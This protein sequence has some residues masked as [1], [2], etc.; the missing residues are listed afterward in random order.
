[1]QNRRLGSTGIVVSELCLGTMT[2]GSQNTEAEAFAIMDRA[3]DAGID[4]L[5]TAELYPVPPQSDWVYTCEEIVGRWLKTKPR[6]AIYLATKVAG[7]GHGWFKPPV[8]H[9]KTTLD[10]HSIRT[11]IEGSLRR[12]QTDY[13]DLY[14][15]HWPDHDFGYEETMEALSE[16]Q[17]QGLIRVAGS[18]NEDAWGTMK[19]LAVSEHTGCVRYETIQNNFS[20]I[21]RRFED[22]LANICRREKVSCLP[23]S[24][25]GGGVCTGK[26]NGGAL[27]ERAR[28]TGYLKMKGAERQHAM[29]KRFVNE[30]SLATVD[31]L[32]P[33]AAELG[34][35]LSAF[36]LAWSKQHD[37]VASTIFGATSLEQLEDNLGAIDL[38]IPDDILARIDDISREFAYPMG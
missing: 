4:F 27:P 11:A 26:Y 2:F 7:A 31:A 6:D 23:Y 34:A 9:G 28:F 14:Q 16:L 13:I 5:D 32:R 25:L 8:R 30:R 21:N 3:F 37:F 17:Q 24:P 36:C 12:L 18:S 15:T 22:E 19:A 1:M 29:A 35:S 20:I 38:V 10:R 33:L